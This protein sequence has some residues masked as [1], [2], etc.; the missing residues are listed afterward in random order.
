MAR[1]QRVYTVPLEPWEA[2]FE[3]GQLADQLKTA[4]DRFAHIYPKLSPDVVERMPPLDHLHDPIH[5]VVLGNLA[6]AL[7]DEY[8]AAEA[9]R[10]RAILNYARAL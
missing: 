3:L 9:E 2:A 5:A 7:Q 10:E 1:C 8:E 6:D 4:A